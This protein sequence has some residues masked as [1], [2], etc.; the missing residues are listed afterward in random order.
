[1]VKSVDFVLITYMF[2]NTF[3]LKVTVF[4][5][6]EDGKCKFALK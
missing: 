4:M 2:R 1:M 3:Y 5:D 6:V